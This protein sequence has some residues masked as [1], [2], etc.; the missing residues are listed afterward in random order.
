VKAQADPALYRRLSEPFA[1]A[2]ELDAA[3]TAFAAEIRA[4]REKHRIPDVVYV[5]AANVKDGDGERMMLMSGNCGNPSM[6]AP[7]LRHTLNQHV[8]EDVDALL[9][10][11]P[12]P[13]TKEG[14][15]P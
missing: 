8:R 1:T 12:Q 5:M 7:L 15:E 14:T 2:E 4:L 10:M 6:V 13:T 3:S 9:S 11:L